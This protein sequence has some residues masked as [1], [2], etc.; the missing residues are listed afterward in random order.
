MR[1]FLYTAYVKARFH[2]DDPTGIPPGG[3]IDADWV[4]E[5]HGAKDD[6]E[7]AEFVQRSRLGSRRLFG[8][9]IACPEEP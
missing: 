1:S 2:D 4:L 7:I 3:H 5:L 8:V 9:L 6:C